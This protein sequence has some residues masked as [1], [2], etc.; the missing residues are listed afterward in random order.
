MI[1]PLTPTTHLT[2]TAER[3]APAG[4]S[5]D[6]FLHKAPAWVRYSPGPALAPRR[7]RHHHNVHV[8]GPLLSILH[9]PAEQGHFHPAHYAHR[10]AQLRQSIAQHARMITDRPKAHHWATRLEQ[11]MAARLQ[12]LAQG[13]Q[14]AAQLLAC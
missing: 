7:P 6:V 9:T 11:Q 1:S 2:P 3:Q 10:L 13:R 4:G 5:Q 14:Q 8:D 12:L